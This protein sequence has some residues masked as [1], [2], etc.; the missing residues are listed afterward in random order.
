M[1]LIIDGYNLLNAAGIMPRS[2]G[3]HTLERARRALLNFLV[4]SLEAGERSRT[5]V[6]FDAGADAPRGLPRE[7]QFDEITVRYASQY[8]EADTLIEELIKAESAPRNLTVVSSDHRLQ[9]AARRRRARGVDSDRWYAEIVARCRGRKE[10]RDEGSGKPRTSPSAD[11][12]E[13]WT[14]QF[15]LDDAELPNSDPHNPFP[16]GYGEDLLEEE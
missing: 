16:P 13:Y 2:A 14:K 3:P 7:E 9:R 12:V 8:D 1:S 6:V 15:E 11:E 5:T 10:P 4:A